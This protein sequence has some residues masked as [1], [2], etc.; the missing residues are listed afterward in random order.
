[1]LQNK[2][3]SPVEGSVQDI[4]RDSPENKLQ[5]KFQKLVNQNQK[6]SRHI[7]TLENS[8]TKVDPTECPTPKVKLD[9][10]TV[11]NLVEPPQD[12]ILAGVE[13]ADKNFS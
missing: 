12:I 1:M 7:S 10:L 9:P 11:K 2:R 3:P 8:P 4:S 5:P 13:V 6:N